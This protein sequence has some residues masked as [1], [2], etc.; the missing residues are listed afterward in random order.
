MNSRI[1]VTKNGTKM[2]KQIPLNTE[3][4]PH[5]FPENFTIIGRVVSIEVAPPEA[6]PANFPKYFTNNGVQRSVI[7]SRIMFDSKAI[8][9]K[10]SPLIWLIKMLD[11]L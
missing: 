4:I 1:N 5:S 3:I 11:K 9:P 7:I 10:V 2:V 8:T 6:I